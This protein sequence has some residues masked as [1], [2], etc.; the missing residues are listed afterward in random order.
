MSKVQVVIGLGSNLGDRA[1]YLSAA[2]RKLQSLSLGAFVQSAVYESAAMGGEENAPAYL[3][4][5]LCFESDLDPQTLLYTLKGFER[6]LGRRPRGFWMSREIDLDLLI[7]GQTIYS[8]GRFQVPHGGLH[9]RQFMLKP[10][11]EIAP[12]LIHPKL[13]K[14]VAKLLSDLVESQGEDFLPK[15]D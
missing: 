13:G 8:L 5:V 2:V 14:T 7:H 15:V 12:D 9:L 3:N 1:N 4:Q 10:L 11:A 6:L